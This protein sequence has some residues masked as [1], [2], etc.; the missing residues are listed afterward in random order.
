MF[1]KMHYI[2]F[3]GKSKFCTDSNLQLYID[4]GRL[5]RVT[6]TPFLGIIISFGVVQVSLHFLDYMFYRNLLMIWIDW[7]GPRE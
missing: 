6:S 1:K 7:R 4:S 5:E 2:V 3:G